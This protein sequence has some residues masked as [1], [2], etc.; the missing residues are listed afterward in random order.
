[1][2]I[3]SQP[4]HAPQTT[5]HDNDGDDIGKHSGGSSINNNFI[6]KFTEACARVPVH[7]CETR[8]YRCQVYVCVRLRRLQKAHECKHIKRA[9]ISDLEPPSSSEENYAAA[10]V[11]ARARSYVVECIAP[12][13][14]SKPIYALR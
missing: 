10:V 4:E 12:G 14:R 7:E 13:S 3:H 6:N 8:Y 2:S 11:C 5:E 9:L 1:M